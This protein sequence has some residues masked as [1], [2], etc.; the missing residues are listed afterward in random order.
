MAIAG[1]PRNFEDKFSF[2]V[3]IDGIAH[4][5]FNKCSELSAELDTILYREG[6]SLIPSAKDPGL[7]NFEAVTLERGAVANDSDLYR[8]FE[9]VA[10]AASNTGRVNPEF[11]RGLDIVAKDRDGSVLKRWRLTRA[12]AK[13]FVA[14]DWDADA[15]EKTI[16]A[17][18]LEF[19]YFKRRVA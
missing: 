4:A 19:D 5:A 12:W 17:V 10:D 3:E 13:K 7:L 16:E 18:T 8:W 6:G 11:K 14:G 9:E 1:A 2:I 15:S